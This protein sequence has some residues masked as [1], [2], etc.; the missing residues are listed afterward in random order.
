MAEQQ[1]GKGVL[2]RALLFLALGIFFLVYALMMEASD[3]RT[4]LYLFAGLD[5]V[6]GG[7]LLISFFRNKRG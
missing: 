7:A 6:W 4:M 3:F 5:I 2:A 1:S